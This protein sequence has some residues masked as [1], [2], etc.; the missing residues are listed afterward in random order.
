MFIA[1]IKPFELFD[2][3]KMKTSNKLLGIKCF[4]MLSVSPGQGEDDDPVE[5]LRFSVQDRAGFAA[6]S[7]LTFRS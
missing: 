6:W 5:L 1:N 7:G 4:L 3:V 2:F